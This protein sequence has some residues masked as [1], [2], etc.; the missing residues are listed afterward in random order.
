MINELLNLVVLYVLII[1]FPAYFIINWVKY[2]ISGTRSSIIISLG[3]APLLMSA[4]LYYLLILLPQQSIVFYFA[5]SLGC[6]ISFS[7][8]FHKIK[9]ATLNQ[10]QLKI[11]SLNGTEKIISCLLLFLFLCSLG[12]SFWRPLSEHDT[13]EYMFL[14][15]QLALKKQLLISN[16]RFDEN[17]G[18]FFVGLHG[19]LYPLLFTWQ[20]FI[21]QIMHVDSEWWFKSLSG[22]YTLLFIAMFAG[23]IKTINQKLILFALALIFSTYA[24]VFSM[25]QFHLEMIRLFL[26]VAALYLLV[27]YI[28]SAKNQLKLLGLVLGLQASIHFIGMVISIISFGLLFLFMQNSFFKR[29][30]VLSVPFIIFIFAGLLHYILEYWL[31]DGY[32]WLKIT[33]N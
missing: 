4:L 32:W 18:S 26:F 30:K 17:S 13:F 20:V 6:L 12:Y 14:G 22:F 33:G 1:F 27:S 3:I 2:C 7:F 23:F 11:K 24:I 28:K 5:V 16:Y 25:L 29:V 9:T 21:N 10:L 8:L 15:K 19:L 31:G